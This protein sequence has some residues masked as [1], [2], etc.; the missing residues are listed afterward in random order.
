MNP[1]L[2]CTILGRK[3]VKD[4][5][6]QMLSKCFRNLTSAGIMNTDKCYFLLFHYLNHSV[7]LTAKLF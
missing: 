6:C 4:I 2:K 5:S 1:P 3:T 7:L